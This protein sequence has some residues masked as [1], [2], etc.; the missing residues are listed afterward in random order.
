M[1]SSLCKILRRQ[2]TS[3]RHLLPCCWKK[4]RRDPR[5]AD[6]GEERPANVFDAAKTV[7]IERYELT[8]HQRLTRAV[9]MR[10][11]ATDEK[12]SQWT[13]RFRQLGDSWDLEDIARW[14]LLRRLPPSLRTSLKLPTPQLST[15]ELLREADSLYVT[16]PPRRYDYR[17]VCRASICSPRGDLS[18]VYAIFK[19]HAGKGGTGK[20]QKKGQVCW[21]HGKFGDEFRNCSG[22]PCP[23]YRSNLKNIKPI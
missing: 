2:S 16:L 5:S 14:A 22:P 15:E 3:L 12:P 19:G 17:S 10:G 6:D 7:F 9:A 20:T 11:I 4:R 8:V 18:A 1:T 21:Y 23:R 13:V